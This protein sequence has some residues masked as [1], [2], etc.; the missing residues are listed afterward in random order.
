MLDHIFLT[1]SDT[2]RSIA[3]Y[4][5]VLPVLGI[6]RRLDYDGRDGPTGHPD[7]KGFGAGGRMFFWL[8]QGTAAPGAVH[9]G[10]VA[11]SA[12][13]VD[14]AHAAALAAGATQI[15]PPG[16]QLHYDPRYYAAQVRDPDGYSLEFVYKSWQHEH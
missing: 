5:Q 2:D 11:D 12:A 6:T 1:V 4:E 3:F 10:L 16:P 7:L 13:M 14:T 15:H 8:R 9:V